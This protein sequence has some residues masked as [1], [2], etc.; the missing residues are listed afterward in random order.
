MSQE[1]H[2]L[3]SSAVAKLAAGVPPEHLTWQEASAIKTLIHE[4]VHGS[5]RLREEPAEPATG[6]SGALARMWRW[7]VTGGR[8]EQRLASSY[9]G[10]G[11]WI[12]E[13][14]TE[15]TAR[16]VTRDAF[17]AAPAGS[18][19]DE[20][21]ATFRLIQEQTG[22]RPRDAWRI[23]EQAS[24][25]YRSAPR[26]GP[27]D[28]PESALRQFLHALHPDEVSEQAKAAIGRELERLASGWRA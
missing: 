22:A 16:A 6:V 11:A 15:V 4:T 3:A 10:V 13:V 24:W 19:S 5:L 8:P 2:E 26:N 27:T 1:R 18:Y 9:Q 21:N 12:E 7:Y 14:T 23:L 25:R 28:T 20:I 17:G